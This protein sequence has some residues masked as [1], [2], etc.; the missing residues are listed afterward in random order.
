MEDHSEYVCYD[1]DQS[2]QT[3]EIG[4]EY[5]YSKEQDEIGDGKENE[6]PQVVTTTASQNVRPKRPVSRQDSNLYDLPYLDD[7]QTNRKTNVP[8][9]ERDV[10]KASQKASVPSH[11]SKD[12]EKNGKEVTIMV[13]KRCILSMVFAIMLVGAGAGAGYFYAQGMFKFIRQCT[14][15]TMTCKYMNRR[16]II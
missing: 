13:D 12:L 15:P 14:N 7:N 9:T 10:S 2:S 6:P 3:D 11:R 5:L 16:R 1:E 8:N 4:G